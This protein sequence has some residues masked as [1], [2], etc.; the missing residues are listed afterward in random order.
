[1]YFLGAK[2]R[3]GKKGLGSALAANEAWATATGAFVP[4][5]DTALAEVVGGHFDAHPITDY[6]ADAM[7]AHF[8][9]CVGDD[10]VV[11]F[12]KDA[13]AP[14]WKDF[15]DLAIKGQE[16]LFGHQVK[17]TRGSR[18]TFCRDDRFPAHT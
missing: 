15:V 2:R 13:K 10:P 16:I 17:P 8:T 6:R 7:L 9:R 12:Q 14:I 4:E 11:V 1:M 18:Q 5:N 3:A